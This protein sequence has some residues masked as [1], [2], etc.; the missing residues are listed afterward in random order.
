M[1]ESWPRRRLLAILR[2]ADGPLDAGQLAQLTGQHVT[3][4]RFHLDVLARDSLVRQV[5]Q[6]PRGRGRPRI[7]Y[8][9]VQ[10]SAGYQ[11]LA[12]VLADQLGVDR[13]QRLEAAVRAGRAWAA[14][15]DDGAKQVDDLDDA[16]RFALDLLGELGFAPDRDV[17]ADG[18]AV[19]IKLA[20]CPMRD[21]A[22]THSEVV[23]GVHLGLLRELLDR[24]STR[25]AVKVNLRPFVGP[26]RCLV[27]LSLDQPHSRAT[28]TPT[29]S[30]SER[31][32]GNPIPITLDGS[33]SMR[34]TN[35]PPSPS[36]VNAPATRN[37]SP[38]AR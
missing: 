35:Q 5:P 17:A 10:R 3:T 12:Q 20:G 2:D 4:V 21:L 32:N 26:E 22:R 24:A 14:K 6:P 31:S 38:D 13:N 27:R 18:Q 19:T 25:N 9:A 8:T 11:E 16:R 30:R 37:G 34:S 7:G 1:S 15:L 29:S 23:C 36:R 33:P 28:L